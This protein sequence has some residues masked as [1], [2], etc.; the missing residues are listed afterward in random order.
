MKKKLSGNILEIEIHGL[1]FKP[2]R[3]F[4]SLSKT[5][6]K[7]RVRGVKS[8]YKGNLSSCSEIH[9]DEVTKKVLRYSIS[10]LSDFSYIYK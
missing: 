8:N 6:N 9:H 4:L 3:W 5:K 2:C 1:S 10:P 7:Y